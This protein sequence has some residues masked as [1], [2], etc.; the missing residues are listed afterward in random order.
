MVRGSAV[1]SPAEGLN[2]GRSTVFL[3]FKC[4]RWFPVLHYRIVYARKGA[5]TGGRGVRTPQIWTEHPNFFD[6]ECDYRYVTDYSERNWVYHP[7]F[8]L[9]NNL[10]QGIGPPTLKTWLRP[11]MHV[12]QP[13][14]G[15]LST[16]FT[17]GRDLSPY[18]SRL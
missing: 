9:Y 11:C 2:L 5:T 4:S 15:G 17:S 16:R 3:D 13:E 18:L 8:V 14:S 6:E 12:V 1:S 7:Y 10:H